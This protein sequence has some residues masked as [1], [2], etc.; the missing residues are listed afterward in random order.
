MIRTFIAVEISE[1]IREQISALVDVLRAKGSKVSWVRPE[2]LHLTLKFLGDV[3][4]DRIDDVVKGTQEATKGMQPFTLSFSGLGVFPGFKR[5][6]VIWV[7]VNKGSDS[8][9]RLQRKIEEELVRRGFERE[10]RRFS[11]HLTIGRVRTPQGINELMSVIRGGEFTSE[12]T[13][14]ERVVVM[15]SD[16]SPTGAVYSPLGICTFTDKT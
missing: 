1:P 2:N 3:E 11:P 13:T 9:G 4:E 15:K 6:R 5:P 10:K 14:V 8:L 12:E 16:L 7:G